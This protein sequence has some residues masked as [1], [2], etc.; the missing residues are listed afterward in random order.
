[1]RLTLHPPLLNLAPGIEEIEESQHVFLAPGQPRDG[2]VVL[3]KISVD[4]GLKWEDTF[5]KSLE[6]TGSYDGFSLS[7]KVR[8]D[9]PSCLLAEQNRD[10]LFTVYK[11]NIGRQSQLG[12]LDS[13]RCKFHRVGPASFPSGWWPGPP[14]AHTALRPQVTAE[15]AKEPWESGY[16][17]LMHCSLN[18][19]NRHCRLV[20]E[21]KDCLQGAAAAAPLHAVQRRSCACGAASLPSWIPE[22]RVLKE[23]GL[24]EADL[25]RRQAHALGGPE[26]LDLTY[27]P[28]AEAFPPPPH[29]FPAPLLLDASPGA[30]PL[31]APDLQADPAA[32]ADQGC[33]I[34]F[35]VLEDMLRSL[36]AGPPSEG[37]LGEGAGAG[38]AAGGPERRSVIQFSPPF[39]RAQAPL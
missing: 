36:H 33:D 2:Q 11:P 38:G 30:L 32:L 4:C 19:W 12:A 24:I 34:N 22:G 17:L 10:Q 18:T 37:A 31:G 16:S 23:L 39:P 21:G 7:Y 6:L 35:K 1:M 14:Q 5:A 8:G 9:K 26:V 25:K 20:Q 15:E 3:Y 28:P 27:S 29:F 13:L